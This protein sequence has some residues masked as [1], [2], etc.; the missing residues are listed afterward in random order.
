MN[1]NEKLYNAITLLPDEMIQEVVENKSQSNMRVTIVRF[2]WKHWAATAAAVMLFLGAVI[3][4]PNW[5]AEPYIPGAPGENVHTAAEHEQ[6]PQNPDPS[7]SDSHG[8]AAPVT[9]ATIVPITTDYE[10]K[11]NGNDEPP[12]VEPNISLNQAEAIALAK[13]KADQVNPD[14][15]AGADVKSAVLV[16]FSDKYVWQVEIGVSHWGKIPVTRYNIDANTGKIIKDYPLNIPENPRFSEDKVKI[17]VGG[18][19]YHVFENWNHG[20]G[21]TFDNCT[22]DGDFVCECRIQAS[23]RP[24]NPWNLTDILTPV[25]YSDDFE[26]ISADINGDL[27]YT[28]YNEWYEEVY[29]MEKVLVV[30]AQPGAYYLQIY[31]AT[32][33]DI[34]CGGVMWNSY[35]FWV[36]IIIE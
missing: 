29:S 20:G 22:Y 14:V 2:T 30:S 36:K 32:L 4:I 17:K 35:D 24:Q 6:T 12:P 19:E 18:I 34:V 11:P 13:F 33:S 27:H 21:N 3:M 7:T 10:Q 16:R 15:K 9:E 31:G 28:L 25:V 23:G 5:G 8:A 26:V 1:N